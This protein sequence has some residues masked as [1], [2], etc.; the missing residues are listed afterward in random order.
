LIAFHPRLPEARSNLARQPKP[1]YG[2]ADCFG[3]IVVWKPFASDVSSFECAR[4]H[5]R[6]GCASKKWCDLANRPD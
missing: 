1:H 6:R 5:P 4:G 3:A 2:A